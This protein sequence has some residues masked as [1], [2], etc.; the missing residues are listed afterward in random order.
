MA[1]AQS[2]KTNPKKSTETIPKNPNAGFPQ[3]QITLQESSWGGVSDIQF[4]V[5]KD[6]AVDQILANE[7]VSQPQLPKQELAGNQV[8]PSGSQSAGQQKG[9][10]VG[11]S[12]K[13]KAVIS[14]STQPYFSTNH[15]D[16]RF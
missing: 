16:I 13:A 10:K 15:L 12:P 9:I 14:S 1:K 3:R 7:P 2:P 5:Q 4:L 8:L 6:Q 11:K